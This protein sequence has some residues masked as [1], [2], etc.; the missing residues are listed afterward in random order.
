MA[1]S[2]SQT[3]STSPSR[4]EQTTTEMLNSVP[5]RWIRVSIASRPAGSRPLVGSSSSNRS[6][7]CTSACA[8]F[9]RCFMPVE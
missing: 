2:Q 1:T 6:G 8:S 5:I 4:C 7:S 3:R 9:T